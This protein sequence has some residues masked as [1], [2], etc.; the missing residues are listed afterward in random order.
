MS[1]FGSGN[2]S[3]SVYKVEPLYMSGDDLIKYL[4]DKCL[5]IEGIEEETRIGWSSRY[6]GDTDFRHAD[7]ITDKEALFM[8]VKGSRKASESAVKAQ[9]QRMEIQC[10]EEQGVSMLSRRRKNE[11][12]ADIV[13]ALSKSAPISYSSTEV[14]YS[15]EEG[16]LIIESTSIP[17]CDSIIAYLM[18]T[19][20]VEGYPCMVGNMCPTYS[21]NDHEPL[22]LRVEDVSDGLEDNE[23]VMARDF[24]M[25]LWYIN[26]NVGTV[27]VTIY[28]N[29]HSVAIGISG[30]LQFVNEGA[31]G[32]HKV[33]VDKGLPTL[34]SEAN[35]ALGNGKKL[36]KAKIDLALGDD[37]Y[38]F[39][40]DADKTC[41]S[42][43]KLPDG[44]AMSRMDRI[45]ERA[46]MII[47]LNE[48]ITQLVNTF[49][50]FVNEYSN[51][52]DMAEWAAS[53]A[54]CN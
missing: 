12:K 3:V 33:R 15:F 2:I 4:E 39:T 54:T 28:G 16:Y 14:Y 45:A 20:P 29:T 40:F 17:V 51:R 42:G 21:S 37:I 9:C 43:L 53:R 19:F 24:L 23:M 26:E 32:A 36:Q 30:P 35:K 48:I 1:K 47:Q 8:Y 50:A 49:A 25:W 41:Y 22:D 11:I 6:P 10:M 13:A 44:E 34:A 18:E 46:G 27:G 7:L 38:S 31:G 52:Q 5:L